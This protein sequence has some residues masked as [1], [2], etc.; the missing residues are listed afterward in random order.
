MSRGS[1]QSLKSS[2]KRGSSVNP[3]HSMLLSDYNRFEITTKVSAQ[4]LSIVPSWKP[5]LTDPQPDTIYDLASP[6]SEHI[7]LLLIYAPKRRDPILSH[8]QPGTQVAL[9]GKLS[10]LEEHGN[11]LVYFQVHF[12]LDNKNLVVLE[13]S[14]SISVTN[15]VDNFINCNRKL[16]LS[17]QFFQNRREEDKTGWHGNLKHLFF[18][19]VVS[20]P[21]GGVL[22]SGPL[23]EDVLPSLSFFHARLDQAM[24][25]ATQDF[26]EINPAALNFRKKY[27]VDGTP[28]IGPKGQKVILK[29]VIGVEEDVNSFRYS[30]KGKIDLVFSAEYFPSSTQTQSEAREVILE[31]KTGKERLSHQHQAMLYQ[32]GASESFDPLGFS[33]LFYSQYGT[34]TWVEN[35][36]IG[37]HKLLFR[38]NDMITVLKSPLL[39]PPIKDTSACDRYCGQNRA[40]AVKVLAEHA[41]VLGGDDLQALEAK[42]VPITQEIETLVKEKHASRSQILFLEKLFQAVKHEYHDEVEGAKSKMEVTKGTISLPELS[43][44]VAAFRTEKKVPQVVLVSLTLPISSG[45]AIQVGTNA[46]SED[47]IIRLRHQ[48]LKHSYLRGQTV[49]VERLAGKYGLTFHLRIRM[50]NPS[51]VTGLLD[52]ASESPGHLATLAKDWQVCSMDRYEYPKMNTSVLLFSTEKA[53]KKQFTILKMANEQFQEAQVGR[54]SLELER[55]YPQIPFFET[56]EL[57][58]DQKK[59]LYAILYSRDFVLVHGY[60]GCGKTEVV[61]H[62]LAYAIQAQKR[63]LIT[64]Y[65]HR[66]LLVIAN[67]LERL[68]RPRDHQ[69]VV[70]LVENKEMGVT[71]RFEVFSPPQVRTQAQFAEYTEKSV[72][73]CPSMSI[74]KFNFQAQ[75]FDYVL[76]DEA[77]QIIEPIL[78]D[79]LGIG[80]KFVMFGDYLQLAPIQRSKTKTEQ[81]VK[82]NVSLLEKMCKVFPENAV[83]LRIQYRMN[84]DILALVNSLF[85]NGELRDGCKSVAG[86]RLELQP[87][88]NWAPDTSWIPQV[89]FGT[90]N[91]GVVFVDAGIPEFSDPFYAL[92]DEYSQCVTALSSKNSAL[93]MENF[94]WMLRQNHL[95]DATVTVCESLVALGVPVADILVITTLNKQRQNLEIKLVRS[96]IITIDRAQGSDSRVVVLLLSDF[97]KDDSFLLSS[98]QRVNVAISRAK[99]KLIIVGDSEELARYPETSRLVG[100]LDRRGWLVRI[101]SP[102]SEVKETE[103]FKASKDTKAT[104]IGGFGDN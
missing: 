102:I 23:V 98:L 70:W 92:E 3:I 54:K 19:R 79:S 55:N 53:T 87:P 61:V 28:I 7:I 50:D 81:E 73:F 82:L 94:E 63:V 8:L 22:P 68:L 10:V 39:P 78:M 16:V 84:S 76:I 72:Y 31:L 85:Y 96:Q 75:D 46:I 4:D 91:S 37:L 65:T 88:A 21:I 64:A 62:F 66:S 52:K 49:K 100:E 67:R 44:M 42:R 11:S 40:C 103:A 101:P 41:Q 15:L 104:S 59:A 14:I 47:Q 80:A 6:S 2:K 89:L 71:D 32:I 97:G 20:T 30:F 43:Q 34:L 9:L 17:S 18:S 86:Q 35:E 58:Q 24:A 51:D 56:S 26:A 27:L 33:L 45:Q 25:Q 5:V 12:P 57:N 36:E 83:H 13:P 69:Q 38:R 48:K 29:S 60:P 74:R 93:R 99:E 90:E 77:S 95:L 1:T